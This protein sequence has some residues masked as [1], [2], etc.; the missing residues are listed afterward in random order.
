MNISNDIR[1]RI[2]SAAEALVSEGVNSPT[3]EQV[4]QKLGGGSLSHISPVMREWRRRLREQADTPA[5]PVPDTLQQ[6]AVD[7]AARLWQQACELAEGNAA[8]VREQADADIAQADEQRDEALE[9]V[10]RLEAELTFL[11]GV[12]DERDQLRGQLEETRA[13]LAESRTNNAVMQATADA[14]TRQLEDTRAE[15]KLAREDNRALQAE[16]LQLARAA[17]RHPDP[18]HTVTGTE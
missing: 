17:G 15:L 3:N 16:L 10:R 7:L 4:R 2:E 14:G 12:A 18:A 5:L 6:L 9:E 1:A 8:A 11:R 13:A